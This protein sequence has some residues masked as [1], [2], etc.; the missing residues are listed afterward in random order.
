MSTDNKI[1]DAVRAGIREAREADEREPLTHAQI[2][3]MSRDE[4]NERW[5]EVSAVLA[6]G[7]TP[8]EKGDDDDA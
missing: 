6:S 5:D 1:R 4:I 2:K 3:A 8:P 7:P